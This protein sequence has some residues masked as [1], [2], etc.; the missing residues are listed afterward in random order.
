MVMTKR[1]IIF[2]DLEFRPHPGGGTAEIAKMEFQNGA[3]V[4]VLR[5][6]PEKG[7][8]FYAGVGTYELAFE[9]GQ[10][11]NIKVR[12]FVT[13]KRISKTMRYLQQ[14]GEK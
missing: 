14:L 9:N 5:G 10:G 11:G 7:P 4:S 8:G 13:A 12:S 2:S 6:Q 1:H 3:S